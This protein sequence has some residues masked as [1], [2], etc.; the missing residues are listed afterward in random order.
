MKLKN[1]IVALLIGAS[2]HSCDYLDIVPDDTPILADA[3]K[4]E[5]TAENFVF[6]CYSFIP[7]YLNF[8]QNF[9]CAQ[10]RKLSDLPLDHYLVHLYENATRIVQFC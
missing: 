3:F 1:I 9:S 2:L 5:Q 6:A 4:N 10:L 7:N 8:R